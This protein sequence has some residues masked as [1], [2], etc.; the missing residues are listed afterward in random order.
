MRLWGLHPMRN[1]SHGVKTPLI[2]ALLA[3][4]RLGHAELQKREIDL[5]ELTRETMG[6]F[7]EETEKRGIAWIIHPL[8]LVWADPVLLRMALVNLMSNAVKFTG[9]RLH[10]KIE[11]GLFS[12]R[13][14]E[15]VMFIRDNGAGFDSTHAEKLFGIFQRMHTEA[16]FAGTGVG[17]ANVQQIILRHGGRIWVESI[18]D[19]GATFYFSL[20]KLPENFPGASDESQAAMVGD[21]CDSN[22]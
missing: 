4:A 12:G 16:Q 13:P 18:P 17:L 1:G 5:D 6:D 19:G 14:D 22:P 20:P 2:D 9:T 7:Q 8:S 15:T 10:P 3:F 21:E 11:M